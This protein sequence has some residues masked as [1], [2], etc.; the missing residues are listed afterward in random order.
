LEVSFG[1]GYLLTRYAGDYDTFGIDL[2]ARLAALTKD[3]LEAKG[4]AVPIAIGNVE[5]L[6]YPT[7]CFDCVV[8]TMALTGYPDAR[9]AL[10]EIR[11]VLKPGGRLVLIDVNYPAD[12]NRVG[13]RLTRAWAALGDLI[14]DMEPLFHDFGFDF[15]DREIGGW[16][17]VHLYVADKR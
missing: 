12:R 17:S 13:M 1:T 6:P 4:I 11:R 5:A 9:Q 14:R 10:S 2:N 15:S 8:D 3:K 16:G 7:G